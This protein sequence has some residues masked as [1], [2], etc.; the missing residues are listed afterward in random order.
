MGRSASPN[1]PRNIFIETSLTY[2]LSYVSIISAQ[3][4]HP[5]SIK[6][7]ADNDY[8]SKNTASNTNGK[9]MNFGLPINKAHKTG[10]GS[11]AALV[12]TLTAALLI[13]HLP[14]KIDLSSD[15][16]LSY[17][18]NLAQAAHSAAQ[19]KI[20]SGF[21][22]ASAVYGSCIYRRFSLEILMS[23]G[24]DGSPNFAAR[25]QEVVED[26]CSSAKWDVHIDKR[27][28][29]MPS[30][31]RLVMC[32]V[33]HGSP[34]PG[35]VKRVLSWRHE[36]PEESNELWANLQTQN[37]A[38]ADELRRLHHSNHHGYEEL[39]SRISKIRSLIKQMSE[40][41]N[42]PIEPP[43]QSRLLD[44]CCSIEG[45]I[46]GVVPGAGGFDAIALLIEDRKPV[47]DEL[48]QLF[49]GLKFFAHDR[50][51]SHIGKITMLRVQ[52]DPFGLRRENSLAIGIS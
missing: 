37:D 14:R 21:D 35:M 27:G 52:Q 42:V 28:A 11:S 32:D 29:T 25:L 33:D 44:A 3:S 12:T 39:R 17:V 48:E 10:L 31:L 7:F 5:I 24:E 41:S 34:T 19:G 9:F 30:G 50:L 8:Y 49:A 23:L 4:I 40:L 22:V 47:L 45:V 46:G 15:R 36:K 20:G 2:A 51:A 38:F 16:G 13:H 1:P 18:H 43:E 26:A 6:I